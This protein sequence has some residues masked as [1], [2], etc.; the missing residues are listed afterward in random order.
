MLPP[1]LPPIPPS[2]PGK[3][4]QTFGEPYGDGLSPHVPPDLA[5][6]PRDLFAGDEAA[7]A[8]DGDK[9]PDGG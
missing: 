8:A 7:G 5:D 6:S 1:V 2:V 9:T 4:S 3:P